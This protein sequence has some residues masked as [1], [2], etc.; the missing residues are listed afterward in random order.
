[1]PKSAQRA[2][3]LSAAELKARRAAIELSKLAILHSAFVT[4]CTIA[5]F[6]ANAVKRG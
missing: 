3:L 2:Q 4:I 6:Y 5:G 1:M